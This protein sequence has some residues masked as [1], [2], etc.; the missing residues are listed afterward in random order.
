MKWLM[1]VK[2]PYRLLI[3]ALGSIAVIASYA[4]SI[5]AEKMDVSSAMPQLIQAVDAAP[6]ISNVIHE[7]Q[8]ERGNSAGFI[9]S[10]GA[11][12]F[13]ARLDA[14][15]AS[16]DRVVQVFRSSSDIRALSALDPNLA[17]TL[18]TFTRSLTELQQT[19][20]NVTGLSLT[21]ADMAG[22]YT[23]IIR[24]GFNAL[25]VLPSL[26]PDVSVADALKTILPLMETK[27]RAGIERA[28]G[29]NGFGRGSFAQ[30]VYIRFNTLAGEQ[31]A[32]RATFL[33]LAPNAW[34]S[35]LINAEDSAEWRDVDALREVARASVFTGDT[36]GITGSQWFDTITRKIDVYKSLEDRFFNTVKQQASATQEQASAAVTQTTVINLGIILVISVFALAIQKSISDPLQT[37]GEHADRAFKGEFDQ[38]IPYQDLPGVTGRLSRMI[39]SYIESTR[40]AEELRMQADEEARRANE[41]ERER[42]EMMAAEAEGREQAQQVAEIERGAA[43]T[44]SI[45]GLAGEVEDKLGVYISEIRFSTDETAEAAGS[46]AAVA[47]QMAT[48]VRETRE[49]SDHARGNAEAVQGGLGTVLGKI[50]EVDQLINTSS[51]T[52]D[53]SK[54]RAREAQETVSGLNT[55]AEKIREVV[56][57]INDISEQTNLLALNATIEAARA[58][59]AGKGFAVVASEV[60]S[61]ANQTAKSTE[62]IGRSIDEMRD[63]VEQVVGAVGDITMSSD[64]ISDAFTQMVSASQEQRSATEGMS[65]QIDTTSSD[66]ANASNQVASISETVG[67]VTSMSV[68]LEATAKS[69]SS[70]LE[71]MET[72]VQ[73]IMQAAVDSVLASTKTD[74]TMD[75]YRN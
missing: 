49:A 39:A 35:A 53:T 9:G 12:Q 15:R 68:E 42:L 46:L 64:A 66:I 30:P 21:V 60:K 57:L 75:E 26:S 52:V 55:A 27:E 38:E 69:V 11:A 65:N 50:Q 48:S 8:K 14:Q 33:N 1:H 2:I 61:L 3:L 29:A 73:A 67:Q 58:G 54:V 17:R 59:E 37:I 5:V 13:A 70:Q 32:F 22:I 56:G 45:L 25:Y 20:S 31:Q 63:V 72:E 43:I 40:R 34:R 62:D 10:R 44:A 18:E 19:R 4:I 74:I 41:A 47:E 51:G 16:T 7:L 28:M 36:G 24:E 6:T 71:V 23:R